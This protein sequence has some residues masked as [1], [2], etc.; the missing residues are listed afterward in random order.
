MSVFGGVNQ[1]IQRWRGGAVAHGFHGGFQLLNLKIC[2]FAM[3]KSVGMKQ[4]WR[5]KE[6]RSTVFFFVGCSWK[7]DLDASK[8]KMP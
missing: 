4:I 1:V 5:S 3:A 2:R 6:K 7:V 8:S